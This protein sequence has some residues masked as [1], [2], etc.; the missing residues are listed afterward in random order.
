MSTR[1]QTKTVLTLAALSAMASLI[2]ATTSVN[3][4]IF[5]EDFNGLTGLI[6]NGGPVGQV[7]TTHD[8]GYD[9]NL[10]GWNKAGSGDIHAVDTANTWPGP[11]GNPRNWGVMIW[12]DNVITQQAGIAGSNDNGTPYS[13][14]FLAAGA[15]YEIP[16]QVNNG[17]TDNLQIEVL[18]ASDSAVLHTFNHTPAPP[19][20]VGN[21]GLLPV[22]F[23]YTGDGSGDIKFRIGPGNA[24]QGRFQGTIDDLTLTPEPSAM[25]LC[26]LGLLG[27]R[28]RRR[29]A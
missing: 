21:L 10:A 6:L 28:R 23:N 1:N 13:I 18:R 11:T 3:A 15:V 17:T 4:A 29:R 16:G 9:G 2:L 27:L 14:D 26:A 22:N 25:A 12:Q 8:L 19:V 5:T 24:G 20:G 7:T